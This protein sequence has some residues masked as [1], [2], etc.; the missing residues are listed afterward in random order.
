MNTL[1]QETIT[2]Y[3]D[4]NVGEKATEHVAYP[5]ANQSGSC[6]MP[7]KQSYIQVLLYTFDQSYPLITDLTLT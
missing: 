3:V 7:S 2:T 6:M 4:S 5:V 1:T